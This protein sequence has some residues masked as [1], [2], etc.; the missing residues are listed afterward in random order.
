MTFFKAKPNTE[1]LTNEELTNG[2]SHTQRQSRACNCVVHAVFGFLSGLFC[3]KRRKIWKIGGKSETNAASTPKNL[4]FNS[5]NSDFQLRC[6]GSSTPVTRKFNSG[7]GVGASCI[8]SCATRVDLL[9]RLVGVP[10]G[11]QLA[12]L[13]RSIFWQVLCCAALGQETNL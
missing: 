4:I 7:A 8:R 1:E 5:G 12:Q 13:A 3:E 10:C 9:G 6:P 11:V 2:E